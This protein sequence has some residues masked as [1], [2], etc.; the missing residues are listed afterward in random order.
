MKLKAFCSM[1]LAAGLAV[2]AM[3]QLSITEVYIGLA[4]PDGTDD[5]IE[6][7]NTGTTTITAG[8]SEYFYDDV[9]ADITE[10]GDLPAFSLTPGESL[11]VLVSSNADAA[12]FAEFE[13]VWGTGINLVGTDGGGL[14]QGGDSVFLLDNTGATVDS[15]SYTDLDALPL[16]FDPAASFDIAQ[17]GGASVVGIGG[18]YESN[19]F[20]NDSIGASPD[21]M[22]T[23]IGSPG[24]VPEPATA[25]LLGLG[26]LAMLRRRGA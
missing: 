14:G 20:F 12:A 13:A 19:E 26:G 15:F 7:T 21:F 2:P 9:S 5:W 18:A 16:G 8:A 24:V 6:I 3:G 23:I 25:A 4:G 22:I 1:V 11:V 10:G 17:G